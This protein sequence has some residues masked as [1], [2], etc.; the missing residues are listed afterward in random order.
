MLYFNYILNLLCFSVTFLWLYLMPLHA[1]DL[2][3]LYNPKLSRNVKYRKSYKL[4]TK[5][6]L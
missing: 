2:S 3:T 6:R 5:W 1:V 4:K